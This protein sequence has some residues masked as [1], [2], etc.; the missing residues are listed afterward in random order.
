LKREL[1][2]KKHT[3]EKLLNP[4]Q[5][6]QSNMAVSQIGGSSINIG[7]PSKDSRKSNFNATSLI[8]K[9]GETESDSYNDVIKSKNLLIL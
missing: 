2:N 7:A 3:F 6:K 1:E 4:L 5:Q 9:K 8:S